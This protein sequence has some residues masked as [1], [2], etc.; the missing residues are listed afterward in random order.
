MDRTAYEQKRSKGNRIEYQS[1]HKTEKAAYEQKRGKRDRTEYQSTHKTKKAA[2]DAARNAKHKKVCTQA[3]KD[4]AKINRKKKRAASK[5]K[6]SKIFDQSRRDAANAECE[7]LGA[8][9]NA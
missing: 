2:Y 9:R 5:G 8:F 1:T 7:T 3:E 6:G 4:K